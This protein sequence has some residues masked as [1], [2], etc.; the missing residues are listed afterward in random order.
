MKK[1]LP[2]G[3]QSFSVLREGDYLYVDKTEHI[4]NMISDDGIAYFLS[5]P[6][7][8]GQS[9][10]VSTFD[11]LFS[12]RKELFEGLYIYDKW[13]WTKQY[14]VIRIDW[15]C[16]DHSTP[17]IMETSMCRYLRDIALIYQITIE[18]NTPI[19]YFRELIFTLNR[20]TKRRV[21]I[22]I[23]EYDK[24]ITR[25]IDSAHLKVMNTAVHNFYQ[26]MKGFDEAIEFIFFTGVS[27]FSGLS[28]F[29]V[30][31]NLNYLTMDSKYNSICGYTQEEL[32][33]YFTDYI[34][35]LAEEMN[36]NRNE[37]LDEIKRWYNGYSWDGKTS[38]YNPFA[39]LNLFAKKT[40]DN[41]WF[42][43]GA[44][45]FL[46]DMLKKHNQIKPIVKPFETCAGAFNTYDPAN[47]SEIALLFQTG[48]LTVKNVA[49]DE[50]RYTLYR[51]NIYTLD[52]PNMEVREPFT[53]RLLH[54]YSNYPL[55][56]IR[57]LTREMHRQIGVGDSAGFDHNLRM[58]LANIPNIL[59]K[60]CEGYYHSL[61]MLAMKMLG[62]EIQ[63]E[64]MTN[65]E[66]IDAVMHQQDVI[67]IAEIKYSAE[68]S[69][70]KLLKAA[71]KQIYDNK[72]YEAYLDR[73]I[74]LMAVAFTG[75]EV[76]CEMK[77][78]K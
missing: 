26:V 25:H 56:K 7:L 8:F 71:M 55:E 75:K 68:K 73:R 67:V 21:V 9:L 42:N 29:S 45:T 16:I 49:I 47:I 57:E 14:P 41:Y 32:E 23:D 10:L 58:L 76:K 28:V 70:S 52:I 61:F 44:P 50:E 22:L 43:T 2:I 72:Y 11:E 36:M 35:D 66:R 59:H 39:I 3:I 54:A 17:D 6:R 63:G 64:V 4:Y 19:D 12:G 74:M 34:D 37:V 33:S 31:N 24:P 62:F 1:K 48:Y 78:Y 13:D 53:R 38:V 27:N 5:R 30:L 51:E 40:F 65:I 69:L 46:T 60:D 18:G 20:T 77:M 15:T